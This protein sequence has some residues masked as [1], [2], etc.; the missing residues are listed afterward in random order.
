MHLWCP[1]CQAY[2]YTFIES[3]AGHARATDA[4]KK[5][6]PALQ[7]VAMNF[8][9]TASLDVNKGSGMGL[10]SCD[11]WGFGNQVLAGTSFLQLTIARGPLLLLSSVAI[12]KDLFTGWGYYAPVG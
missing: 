9:Y 6:Y 10:L 5:A 12:E 3:F 8:L 4:V 2:S 11:F 7:S 1:I